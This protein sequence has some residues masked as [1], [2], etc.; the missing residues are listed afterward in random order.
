MLIPKGK[1]TILKEFTIN[2]RSNKADIEVIY[3]LMCIGFSGL[4]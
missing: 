2:I 4:A 1:P 3:H